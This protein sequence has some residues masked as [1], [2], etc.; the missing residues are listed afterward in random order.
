MIPICR[1]SGNGRSTRRSPYG[2]VVP[3]DVVEPWI[4]R[5]T[6]SSEFGHAVCSYY[7]LQGFVRHHPEGKHPNVT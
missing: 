1:E 7:R 3:Q 6:S 5:A 4:E 2:E